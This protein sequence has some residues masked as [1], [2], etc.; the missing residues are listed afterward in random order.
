MNK[1]RI[2]ITEAQLHQI[3]LSVLEGYKCQNSL[4]EDTEA[5]EQVHELVTNPSKA[6][7]RQK[8]NLKDSQYWK[9]CYNVAKN[10][11]RGNIPGVVKSA[12]DMKANN[13][14]R[15]EKNGIGGYKT[16][17]LGRGWNKIRGNKRLNGAVSKGLNKMVK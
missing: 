4:C 8:A 10:G 6:Y 17:I 2:N 1:N 3:V 11:V 12:L 15:A 7:E 16:D 9:D 5:F 14:N 13:Y